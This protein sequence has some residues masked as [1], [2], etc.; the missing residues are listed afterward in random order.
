M[1]RAPARRWT[2]S[3]LLGACGGGEA[4][5][6]TGTTGTGEAPAS[7]LAT[8]SPT[9]ATGESASSSGTASGE[10]TAP[11]TTDTPADTSTGDPPVGT[12]EVYWIDT[13]GGAATLVVAPEGPLM[14]IDA[15]FPGDRDADRIAE[16]VQGE[17]GR[18][19]IELLVV[20][21]YHVDH[22]GGV[23]DLASRVTI[24][25]FWDH[26]DSI[27]AGGGQGLSLWQDYLAVA[28]GRRTVVAAGEAREFG[29][30]Q[31]DIVA[32]DGTVV[33]APLPGAGAANPACD[34]APSMDPQTDENPR[35]VGMV[36]RFGAFDLLD[37]GDL[38]WSLEDQLACPVDRIGPI[39]LYQT[40]HH[41]LNTS[42]AIQLVHAIDPVVAV[43]NNGPRKGGSPSAFEH[44]VSAPGSPDLWQLHRAL[45]TDLEHNAPDD[46]TANFE[47]GQGDAGAWIHA[48]VESD[49]T[50]VV[51]NGRNGH[52]RSYA[53]R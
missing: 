29:G 48:R 7:T 8:T 34:G 35:S 32:S 33:D 51:T 50:F 43:M 27:E 22:V 37:L 36:I 21:H 14:L 28:D 9:G 26:G 31:L 19:T 38:T 4:D 39:D 3:L 40:T 49:G 15:G 47:E 20:T 12:L 17:L 5:P 52:A 2:L 53:S 24:D 46:L 16:V 45:E 41:G 1:P 18:D 44:V 10:S 42:G 11:T 25:A 6:H 13:E 30:L 23:P